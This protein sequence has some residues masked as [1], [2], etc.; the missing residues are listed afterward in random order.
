M[1]CK[2]FWEIYEESGMDPDIKKHPEQCE[3]CRKELEINRILDQK[4]ENLQDYS[5]PDGLW[6]KIN[7]SSDLPDNFRI[8]RSKE[9]A[10]HKMGSGLLHSTVFKR[11]FSIAATILIMVMV[12]LY[13]FQNGDSLKPDFTPVS[14][15]TLLD[16]EQEYFSEINRYSKLVEDNRDEIGSDYYSTNKEKIDVLNDFAEQCKDALSVNKLN[17][18]AQ[19]YLFQAYEEIINTLKDMYDKRTSE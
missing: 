8:Q 2:E 5:A 12:N 18:N 3:N 17:S 9:Y 1:D 14:T 19:K 10:V 16:K 6:K 4:I 11:V 15:E 13:I 7:R